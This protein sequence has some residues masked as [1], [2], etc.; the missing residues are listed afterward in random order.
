MPSSVIRS[1]DYDPAGAPARRRVRQ[2]AA[3]FLSRRARTRGR[4]D[5]PRDLQRRLLQPPHP[6]PLSLRARADAIVSGMAE[7]RIGIGGWTYEPWRGTFFPDKWPHKRELEYAVAPADRD[8]GQRHLL[9]GVQAGD[10]RGLGRSRARRLRVHAQ[11]VALLHQP[12]GARRGGRIG[13]SASSAR[14]SSSSGRSSGRSCGS[15][16]RPRNSTPDDFGAFLKLLPAKQDGVALRH[17]VQ[18]RHDSFHVPEFVDHVP[19]GER[20]DRLCRIARLSG[21]RRYHRRLRLCAAGKYGRGGAGGLFAGGARSIGRR[22]PRAGRRARRRRGCPISAIRR[23]D[24]ARHVHLLHQRRQGSRTRRGASADRAASSGS[25]ATPGAGGVAARP[26]E[27]GGFEHVERLARRDILPR[28]GH[29]AGRLRRAGQLAH[30]LDRGFDL[31]QRQHPAHARQPLARH[32][33]RRIARVDHDQAAEQP[34]HRAAPAAARPTGRARVAA[35]S[36]RAR[37]ADPRASPGC[38]TPR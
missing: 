23:P 30:F 21:D 17:A 3:L 13:R 35:R 8:R 27:R 33:R 29:P 24:A 26:C 2:R 19:R 22:S 9:F 38:A 11:G 6:R 15:S 32:R 1:F 20:R 10:L 28:A 12:Q 14:A 36:D 16:W 4:R 5:A 31:I 37:A 18:V 34:P 7:I 25:G